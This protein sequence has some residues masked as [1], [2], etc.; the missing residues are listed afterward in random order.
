MDTVDVKAL[1]ARDPLTG[2]DDSLWLVFD[3]WE[4]VRVILLHKLHSISY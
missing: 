1:P 3:S 2:E 4:L